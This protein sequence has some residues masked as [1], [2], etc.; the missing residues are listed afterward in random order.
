MMD[1]MAPTPEQAAAALQE[2]RRRQAAL[3][4]R[5]DDGQPGLKPLGWLSVLASAAVF[6]LLGLASDVAS[7][8]WPITGLALLVCL[9]SWL[10]SWL[11]RKRARPSVQWRPSW[12]WGHADPVGRGMLLLPGLI[13]VGVMVF[14]TVALRA[15]GVRWYHALGAFLGWLCFLL[16]TGACQMA[17]VC[18]SPIKVETCT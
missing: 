12:L 8:Y 9:L 2:V 13:G 14:G 16:L 7:W 11:L 10:L 6:G 1:A 4:R 5:G 18:R 15:Q 3:L 17:C